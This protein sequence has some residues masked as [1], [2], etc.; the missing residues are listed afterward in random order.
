MQQLHANEANVKQS[1]WTTADIKKVDVP[2]GTTLTLFRH[3]TSGTDATETQLN[4]THGDACTAEACGSLKAATLVIDWKLGLEQIRRAPPESEL[5]LGLPGAQ[6]WRPDSVTLV[7][8]LSVSRLSRF[9]RI[10]KS[11]DGPVAVSIYLTDQDDVDVLERHLAKRDSKSKARWRDV[12]ITIV[13]PDY[14]ITQKAL[15]KRLRYP[16]NKLRNLALLSATSAYVVV[17]DADFVPSPRMHEVLRTRGVAI[18]QEEA[19]RR[20]H[21]RSPTLQ[22][23]AIVVSAFTLTSAHEGSFPLKPSELADALEAHP[24]QA[25]LTDRNAGHGPSMPSLLLMHSTFAKPLTSTS[26]PTRPWWSF[27]VCFEP[28][29]E[30]YYLIHRASHPLYDERFSDQGG[31]KQSHAILLNSF[32]FEFKVLRDVWFMHPK[33]VVTP[34]NDASQGTGDNG[35]HVDERWPSARL[36]DPNLDQENDGAAGGAQQDHFNF[37]A[38]KDE[39]RYRYFQNFLAEMASRSGNNFRWPRSC[40]ARTVARSKMFGK[41]QA[42]VAFG[43]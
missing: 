6:Q 3:L 5:V 21:G 12:A 2:L 35:D 36:I 11:W 14:T 31:D 29:W 26:S 1:L 23:T 20:R 4:L 41:S 40:D 17:V 43:L 32:G 19:S 22:K 10:L 38:Q 39:Q 33:K 28:Q 24:P 42:L 9:E 8:Q 13:K 37:H 30:P 25:Q 27:N 15:I 7:T 16:I 34:A 18:I